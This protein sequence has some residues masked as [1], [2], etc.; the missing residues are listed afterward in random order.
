MPSR[1][2]QRRCPLPLIRPPST[3]PSHPSQ[4][5][6]AAWLCVHSFACDMVLGARRLAA[7]ASAAASA[8]ALRPPP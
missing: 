8:A 6:G 2:Q 7:A 1:Q 3:S 5:R 4:T